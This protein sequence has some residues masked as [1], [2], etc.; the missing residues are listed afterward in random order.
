M[1]EICLLSLSAFIRIWETDFHLLDRER[2]L[3]ASSKANCKYGH[4]HNEDTGHFIENRRDCQWEQGKR[5]VG[6]LGLADAILFVE[7]ISNKVL[8]YSTG[9]YIQYPIINHN[10]NEYGK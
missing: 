7:G 6:N 9:S 1:E 8:L 3:L 4:Q 10:G 5:W 2:T